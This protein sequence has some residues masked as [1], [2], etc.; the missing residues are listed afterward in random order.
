MAKPK[1]EA[2][3]TETKSR[4]LE[5]DEMVDRIFE[6]MIAG[7]HIALVGPPGT[8]KTLLA[9]TILDNIDTADAMRSGDLVQFGQQCRR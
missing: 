4:L 7:E 8:A 9:E 3:L 1:I 2:F 6:A 5:R